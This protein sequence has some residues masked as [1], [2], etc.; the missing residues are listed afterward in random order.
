MLPTKEAAGVDRHVAWCAA[1]RKEGR[2]L[3]AAAAS[4]VYALAAADPP[5]G[6]EDQVVAAVQDASITR[7]P[8]T[9]R[10]GRMMV[11]ATVAAMMAVA[12]LGFGAV[13]AGRAARFHDQ[14]IRSGVTN[15]TNFAA[16]RRLLQSVEFSPRNS[17][18][19][20]ELAPVGGGPAS[21]Q[22]LTLLAPDSQDM[23][24]VT[25]S[26]LRV[27][28]RLLPLEVTLVGPRRK[29]IVGSISKLDSGGGATVAAQLDADL[30]F[31][32]HVVV[33]DSKGTVLLRGG[34][35][36]RTLQSPTPSP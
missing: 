28:P 36:A 33:R 1:C 12:G 22:A 32:D 5:P 24:I 19:M 31:F 14:A 6:L 9:H 2:E 30:S 4:L 25:V 7:V 10:R 17:V 15:R 29:V 18:K 21:G 11:A 35:T 13:M 3:D 16:F 34:L 8:V 23:S 20:G 27:D 26:A